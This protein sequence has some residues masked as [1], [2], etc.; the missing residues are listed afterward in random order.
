MRPREA[1]VQA[2]I[3]L[4]DLVNALEAATHG[5]EWRVDL[6]TGDFL[7]CEAGTPCPEPGARF[8]MLP[9]IWRA[10]DADDDG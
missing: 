3:S 4:I 5:L 10:V 1:R 7:P 9:T 6:V 8:R 2:R